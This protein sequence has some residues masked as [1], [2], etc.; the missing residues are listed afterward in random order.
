V[1]IAV[2]FFLV[3]SGVAALV[4]RWDAAHALRGSWVFWVSFAVVVCG[5]SIWLAFR[6]T[7]PAV[8]R[9][10]VRPKDVPTP[11]ST[12]KVGHRYRAAFRNASRIVASPLSGVWTATLLLACMVVVSVAVPGLLHRPRWIEAELVIAAWWAIWTVTLSVLL[13]RGWR[14]SDDHVLAPPRVPWDRSQKDGKSDVLTDA[15]SWGCDPIG[16]GALAGCGETAFV[17][18]LVAAILGAVWLMVELALPGLFFLAYYL[19]RTS[20]ARVAN[21]HHDCESQLGRAVVWGMVW[22][23]AYAAPLALVIFVAHR[24]LVK[25]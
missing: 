4:W 19:V 6:E 11:P 13:Y 1:A 23:S 16:C 5:V 14:L 10:E 2:A 17:V 24:L 20:L 9:V 3:C 7:A 21:D 25:E 18:T 15:V 12:A 8:M 22:A